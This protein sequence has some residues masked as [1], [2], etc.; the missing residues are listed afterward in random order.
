[1]TKR[2]KFFEK[3]VFRK[4]PRDKSKASVTTLP[5]NVFKSPNTFTSWSG[6]WVW[7]K[8]REEILSLPKLIFWTRRMCLLQFC[9]KFFYSSLAY[10]HSQLNN[11]EKK[12]KTVQK[13]NFLDTMPG[14]AYC[15]FDN[16][17]KIFPSII[18]KFLAQCSKVTKISILFQ[19]ALLCK[20]FVWTS[21]N[22]VSINLPKFFA[23]KP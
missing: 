20:D 21:K 23:K 5:K 14:Q 17:V 4:S 2:Y 10:F 13:T 16:A 8:I 3:I 6:I 22:A 7:K 19:N 12:P 1:M 18:G 11:F 9:W 15:G